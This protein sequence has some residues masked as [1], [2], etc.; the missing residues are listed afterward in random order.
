MKKTA[1]VFFAVTLLLVV[2]LGITHASKAS[3]DKVI[4]MSSSS[5]DYKSMP[6]SKDVSE[7][8][9]WGD[10]EKGAY[11]E[12]SKFPPGYDAGM[13]THSNDVTIVV[14]KGAYL[15]KDEGGEKRVGP[16]DF[17][18]VPGGHQHWSGGDKSEG[19]LFYTEGDKK[20]DFIPAK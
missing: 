19:A 18:R 16:G 3:P 15:Y 1:V 17:L 14:I 5:A 12:F 11:K 20:F 2:S 9:I 6:N 13:H 8:V 10:P 4:Y 7:A